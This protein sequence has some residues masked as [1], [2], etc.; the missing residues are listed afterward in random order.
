V[1]LDG[2][3]PRVAGGGEN[4]AESDESLERIGGIGAPDAATQPSP[5]VQG[6]ERATALARLVR[7]GAFREPS[8]PHVLTN[9]PAG[10]GE[11]A[12]AIFLGD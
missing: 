10:H 7:R 4:G 9:G 6:D 2:R 11:Q 5:E 3:E 8:L 1:Q 12:P